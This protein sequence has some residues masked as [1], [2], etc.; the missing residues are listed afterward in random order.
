MNWFQI[1]CLWVKIYLINP[2]LR[3]WNYVVYNIYIPDNPRNNEILNYMLDVV[4]DETT[5]PTTPVTIFFE[6]KARDD[7]CEYFADTMSKDN[8][9]A[10]EIW[11]T[12][13]AEYYY[14]MASEMLEY[15][16]I[17]DTNQ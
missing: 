15:M 17:D 3:L 9:T 11:V 13:R 12:Y 1:I 6:N 2:I 8:R 16:W 5:E 10:D 7:F 4:Q 14:D